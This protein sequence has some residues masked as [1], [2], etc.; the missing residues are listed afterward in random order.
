META[1]LL[2][3][4]EG[5][6][7]IKLR[8]IHIC[9]GGCFEISFNKY[10]FHKFSSSQVSLQIFCRKFYPQYSWYTPSESLKLLFDSYTNI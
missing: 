10:L 7:L 9:I 3:R 1:T 5:D 4:S 6:L 2:P 8:L